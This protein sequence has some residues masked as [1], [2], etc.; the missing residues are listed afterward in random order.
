MKMFKLRN[1]SEGQSAEDRDVWRRRVEE[2]RA[3][4]GL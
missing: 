2:A 3:Q 4:I 1:W